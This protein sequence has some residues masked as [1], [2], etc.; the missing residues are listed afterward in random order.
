MNGDHGGGIGKGKGKGRPPE[1]PYGD[2]PNG[3]TNGD[4][5]NGFGAGREKGRLVDESLACR[6]LAAQ[7]FVSWA[8]CSLLPVELTVVLGRCTKRNTMKR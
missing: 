5:V 3:H 8:L 1:A 6:Y 7:C 2:V 4:E